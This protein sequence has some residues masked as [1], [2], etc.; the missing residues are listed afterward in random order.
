M[1]DN[2]LVLDLSGEL[3]I[4]SVQDLE[5]AF[6]AHNGVPRVLVLD[7]RRLSFIDSTGLRSILRVESKMRSLGKRVVLVPGP[8]SVERVFRLTGLDHRLEFVSEPSEVTG[9]AGG[10]RNPE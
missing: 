2:A 3:D 1:G 4:S 5:A 10:N 8:E 7:L 9:Q 6:K